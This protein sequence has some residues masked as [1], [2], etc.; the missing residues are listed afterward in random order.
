M[1]STIFYSWQ[2]DIRPGAA[3]RGFIGQALEDAAANVAQDPALEVDP[4]IERDTQNVPGSPDIG[5]AIFAKIDVAGAFVAD[6]TLVGTTDGGKRTPNPNVLIELGYALKHLTWKRILLVQ[7]TAFGGPELLPFDLRQKRVLTYSSAADAKERASERRALQ[8]RL[9]DA[10]RE[11]F[12]QKLPPRANV[13]VSID[14]RKRSVSSEVHHY[15]L[16]VVA[17]NNGTKRLDDWEVEVEFPTPLLE[18]GVGVGGKV[19]SRSD[20]IRSTFRAGSESFKELRP[21]DKREIR[22]GYRWDKEIYNRKD[23]FLNQ[24]ATAKL[25]VDGQ[26]VATAQRPIS[27]LQ[28]Y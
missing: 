9:E 12:S 22:Y 3:C 26:I 7:N 2:S 21:G 25:S 13:Q 15:E 27:E 20:H 11:V 23:E 10:L 19:N 1:A 24:L 28:D 14:Y 4:A 8:G 17:K 18:P 6:V 16:V 5:A